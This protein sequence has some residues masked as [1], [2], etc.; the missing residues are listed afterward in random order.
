MVFRRG[1]IVLEDGEGGLRLATSIGLSPEEQLQ[2]RYRPGEGVIGQVFVS[3]S[4]IVVPNIAN[5]PRF[6]N[7]TGALDTDS[8][9]PIGFVAVPILSHRRTLG[10]LTIDRASGPM[11]GFHDDLRLLTMVANLLGQAL[12]LHQGV[13]AERKQLLDETR[14]LKGELKGRYSISNAV[15][16]SKLMQEVFSQVHQVGPTRS[17]VLLRGESGTGKEVVARAIHE[18]SPRN[19][20][21][22]VKVNCAA[23]TET[24]LE[25]E[26]FGHEKGAFTGA[27]GERRGR[28][29]LANGGTLFLDEIGDISP[30][31]QAKLL[32]VLQEREVERVGGNR[33]IKI[34][35]RL[36]FATNRDLER[37]VAAG[38][39][40]GDLYYRINVVSICLPP[41]RERRED[42]PPLVAHFIERFNQDNH[43]ELR[44]SSGAM[45]VLY[46]C[47]WP[48]NVRELEN[49]I[50]R[51]ATMTKGRMIEE[52]DFP[53]YSDRCLTRMLHVGVEPAQ[54]CADEC[55]A[56]SESPIAMPTSRRQ[57]ARTKDP[58]PQ[59]R[60]VRAGEEKPEGERERLVWA[61]ERS[62]WVQA[63]AARLLNITARQMGYALQKYQIEVRKF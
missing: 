15:G 9:Q 3:G 21:P 20:G 16:A 57:S 23:L 19:G 26:L 58:E 53:C 47:Y 11:G 14:R 34:D 44:V 2:G 17:T 45:R 24:L 18:L 56:P 51:T 42:I 62:G 61:M 22:F 10:V 13:S 1:M 46:N 43:R 40:R 36:I 55:A 35:V 5:E 28:F 25:S 49:C 31:F 54:V 48:G 7:R 50:E 39:F 60:F 32:R 37:M 63:K 12:L 6:L 59:E 27:S 38:T 4:P 52:L 33:P 8:D 29:E 30:A 41:L